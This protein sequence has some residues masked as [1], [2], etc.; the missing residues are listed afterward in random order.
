MKLKLTESMVEIEPTPFR[1]YVVQ[2]KFEGEVYIFIET[3]RNIIA[4][5]DM[6]DCTGEDLTV[7]ES[8]KFGELTPLTI[9]GCWHDLDRPLYIKVTRPDG[10]IAF[11]GFGTDH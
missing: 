10:S 5:I 4:R 7:W 6:M 1:K 8:E 3:A 11:D 2:G 9:R